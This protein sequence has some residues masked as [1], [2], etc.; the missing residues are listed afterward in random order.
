MRDVTFVHSSAL[1][2]TRPH[3]LLVA[4]LRMASTRYQLLIAA[5]LLPETTATLPLSSCALGPKPTTISV[6]CYCTHYH[7]H[8]SLVVDISAH[9]L[10]LRLGSPIANLCTSV[11]P[12]LMTAKA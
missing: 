5:R 9:L 1:A 4:L 3:Q 6:V 10:G 11:G 8:H 2:A 7:Y 12:D